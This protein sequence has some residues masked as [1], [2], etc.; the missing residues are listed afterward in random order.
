MK[1]MYSVSSYKLGF[2]CSVWVP[3]GICGLDT[4]GAGNN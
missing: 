4:I 1:G 3:R 2:P